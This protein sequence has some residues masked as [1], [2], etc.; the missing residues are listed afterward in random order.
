MRSNSMR[1]PPGATAVA[2]R[3]LRWTRIAS[4]AARSSRRRASRRRQRRARDGASTSHSPSPRSRSTACRRRWSASRGLA[5]PAIGRSPASRRQRPFP[6][7]RKDTHRLVPSA[8]RPWSTSRTAPGPCRAS[9]CPRSACSSRCRASQRRPA[10]LRSQARPSSSSRG[11]SASPRP[12]A[13][14]DALRGTVRLHRRRGATDEQPAQRSEPNPPRRAH[15]G[16]LA[17]RRNAG[18]SKSWPN[19]PPRVTWRV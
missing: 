7:R 15:A 3:P 18:A 14:L 5:P 1:R 17:G 12:S 4:G 2:R 16:T 11:S 9:R 8:P 13:A 10:S 19:A 6:S